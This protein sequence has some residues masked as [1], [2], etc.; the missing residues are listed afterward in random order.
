MMST[1]FVLDPSTKK[2]LATGVDYDELVKG[3]LNYADAAREH[4][5]GL[6]FGVPSGGLYSTVGD[7]A[8]L[9]A[10][11]LGF[12]PDNVL[13]RE[14]LELR[15][16]VPVA[17]NA[18]LSYGYGLGVQTYR[19]GDTVA[20][21]HSGNLAGYTSMVLYDRK[22]KYGVIVLRSAAGGE[23]DAGRLA[24]RVFRRLR[25]PDAMDRPRQ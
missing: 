3:H 11:E 24:G 12:G 4:I 16:G 15:D 6:G 17:A 20:V 10:L 23:A 19:W 8:K 21:G 2:R 22:L 1:G 5:S 7:V 13:R 25:R 9:V 14:A 18:D